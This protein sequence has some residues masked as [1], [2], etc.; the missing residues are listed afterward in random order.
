MMQDIY[1]SR[2][3]VISKLLNVTTMRNT[4]K[5]IVHDKAKAFHAQ[6]MMSDEFDW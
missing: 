4:S 6:E 3:D 1:T 5:F 2:C